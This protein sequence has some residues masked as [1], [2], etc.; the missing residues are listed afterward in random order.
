MEIND[1]AELLYYTY[2]MVDWKSMEQR[3]TDAGCLTC[4][5]AMLSVEVRDKKGLE[6]TGRVCHRCKT[7]FWIKKD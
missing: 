3:P 2:F 4:G 7:V 5:G 1:A 6:Y